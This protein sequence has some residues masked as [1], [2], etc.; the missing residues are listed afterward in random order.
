MKYDPFKEIEK[1]FDDDFFGVFPAVRRRLEP[2][3]DVYQTDKDLVVELQV[4]QADPSKVNIYIN[5][6]VLKIEGGQERV[7]E[8]KGKNYFR[9]EIRMGG[10]TRMLNLPVD[11]KED[12]AKA[13]FQNGILKITLPKAEARR[14]KKIEVQVK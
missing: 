12:E 9:K 6:G 1:L 10:F 11:V 14:G 3:T 5:D 8:E 4:P 2:P 7:E 13:E